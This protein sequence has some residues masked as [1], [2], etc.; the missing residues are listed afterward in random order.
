MRT[1]ST[2]R[3]RLSL[4]LQIDYYRQY[5]RNIVQAKA[6]GGA[7]MGGLGQGNPEDRKTRG[8]LAVI[9][10]HVDLEEEGVI[11]KSNVAMEVRNDV[12]F[13]FSPVQPEGCIE[14]KVSLQKFVAL[15]TIISYESLLDRQQQ[16]KNKLMIDDQV[17]FSV[18]M[19]L[20]FLQKHFR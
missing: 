12:R 19:L 10:T 2:F 8:P 4:E 9:R 3:N 17:Q 13:S 18:N 20:H 7:R 15:S 6:L 5:L 1:H 16:G 14:I 11:V